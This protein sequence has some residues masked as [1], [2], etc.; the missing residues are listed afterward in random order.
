VSST[1]VDTAPTTVGSFQSPPQV[2]TTGAVACRKAAQGDAIDALQRYLAAHGQLPSAKRVPRELPTLWTI[3]QSF[4]SWNRYVEAAGFTPRPYRVWNQRATV[5]AIQRWAE[6]NGGRAPTRAQWIRPSN[7]HPSEGQVRRLFGTWSAAI[8]QAG[9]A[10]QRAAHPHWTRDRILDALCHWAALHGVPTS[11]DWSRAGPGH[12]THALVIRT[13]GSWNEALRAAGLHPPLIQ[14]WSA[15]LIIAALQAWD[16][17]HQRPPRA[18]D[19]RYA[20]A[21]HPNRVL[22]WKR[23]G[24]WDNALRAAG[25]EDEGGFPLC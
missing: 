8:R 7:T 6:G 22:V 1:E 2:A 19:W 20:A 17:T 12:P 3:R 14:K 5:A 15:E 4:G 13:F 23:F 10:P 21:D 9:L 16:R 25:L 24:S 11:G 18:L